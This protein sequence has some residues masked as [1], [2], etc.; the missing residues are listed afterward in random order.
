MKQNHIPNLV[1]NTMTS[2]QYER[3]L[4]A[5]RIS[6][7]EI[8]LV[9]DEAESQADWAQNDD[10]APDY[11]KNRTHYSEYTEGELFSEEV[12]IEWGETY[13]EGSVGLT[14]GL[15]YSITFNGTTYTGLVGKEV[16]ID[17]TPSVA[18]GNLTFLGEEDETNIDLPICIYETPL[19]FE[20]WIF[21]DVP[22]GNYTVTVAGEIENVKQIDNKYLPKAVS[23]LVAGELLGSL[24]TIHSREEDEEY[25]LGFG[26]FATGSYTKASGVYSHAEG[27]ETTASGWTSHAEGFGSFAAGEGSHAEGGNTEAS[28]ESSHAEGYK[29]IAGSDYQH[30]QG[31][32]NI[33]DENDKYAHIVGNGARN[34]DFT[35]QRSN[36]HTIDWE[37]LG[38]FASSVKVGG[39]G[40]DDE[41]A[42]TLATEEYVDTTSDT[43]LAEAKQYTDEEVIGLNEGFTT[44]IMQMYGEDLP[45]EG[46]V[47]IR[48]IAQDVFEE[49]G[50][51]VNT[52]ELITTADIDSLW[53][54]ELLDASDPN[55][56]F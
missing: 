23:N 39:T 32:Y 17:G 4:N 38:W 50:G 3:E 26:A 9:P 37:G 30:V 45:E 14:A 10:T 12:Y 31:K 24:R 40:Q 16:R 43:K 42:K 36:A 41:N 2:K 15:T 53:G 28:G 20:G 35:I 18:I 11:V 6:D 21:A 33:I 8:Y 22:D 44:V 46:L 56:T 1:I 19:Y 48:D 27:E 29:T 7:D 55:T 13:L 5:G 49:S 54:T 34:I 52:A 47:T 51:G 25:K